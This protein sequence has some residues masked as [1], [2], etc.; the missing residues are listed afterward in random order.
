VFR[1]IGTTVDTLNVVNQHF[2]PLLR[3]AGLRDIRWHD[4]QHTCAT[5]LLG[6]RVHPKLVQQLLHLL[7]HASITMTL[8]C[9]SH[10]TATMGRHAA[11]GLD[12]TLGH[13]LLLTKPPIL[14]SRSSYFY[15]ICMKTGSRRADSNRL[16]RLFTSFDPENNR[17]TMDLLEGLRRFDHPTLLVW[18]KEDPHFGPEW[19]SSS[20]G[21]YA[22]HLELLLETDHLLM[23]ER[24]ERFA[25]LVGDFLAGR[26]PEAKGAE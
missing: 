26:V 17:V 12:E 21:T 14:M 2:K 19:G 24:P 1:T 20:A 22:A 11:D 10:W 25:T 16:P 7:G 3:C 5:L 6:R 18:A 15:G 4:L 8:D 13:S 9:H 23:E